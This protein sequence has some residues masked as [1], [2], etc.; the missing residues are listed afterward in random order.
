M[1]RRVLLSGRIADGRS[2]LVDD[3]DYAAVMAAGPW[4]VDFRGYPAHNIEHPLGGA[5][6][7]GHRGKRYTLQRLHQ[8]LVGSWQDHIDQDRLNNQ[9]HNLRPATCAQN[10]QNMPSRGGTSRHRG[11]SW[12]VGGQRWLARASVGGVAHHIGYFDDE[13]E[14]AQAAS[15]FRAEHMPFSADALELSR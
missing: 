5:A 6:A 9:R 7:H 12:S 3:A 4:H 11:V 8:L 14:A 13:D 2:A 1:T 10:N 15:L